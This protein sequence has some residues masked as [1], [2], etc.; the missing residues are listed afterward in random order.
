MSKPDIR[1]AS[2]KEIQEMDE[3]GELYHNPDAPEG[4]EDL[5]PGFWKGARIEGPR[6]A[7]SVHLRL[8]QEVFDFFYE[9]SHGKG[10]LTRMQNVLKSYVEA[11]R[12]A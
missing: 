6:R 8:D 1:R 10:H 12:R 3:R 4:G 2:L 5:P 7:R 11:K 9:E